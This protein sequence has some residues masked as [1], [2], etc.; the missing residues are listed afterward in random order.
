MCEDDEYVVRLDKFKVSE[1]KW[2]EFRLH[3]DVSN[4]GFVAASSIYRFDKKESSVLS[5]QA[6]REQKQIFESREEKYMK[7][8]LA[9]HSFHFKTSLSLDDWNAMEAKVTKWMHDVL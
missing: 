6:F 9:Q 5:K 1:P 3:K 2:L 4:S 7:L 8:T